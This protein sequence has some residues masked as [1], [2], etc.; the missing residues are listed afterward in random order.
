MESDLLYTSLEIVKVPD[1]AAVLGTGTPLSVKKSL[2]FFNF[3]KI[4]IV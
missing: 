4:R 3:S 2:V 1:N